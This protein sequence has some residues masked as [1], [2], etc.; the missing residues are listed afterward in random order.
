M[1]IPVDF[2][3]AMTAWAQRTPAVKALV[4]IGSRERKATDEIWR[5]DP[6]SDWD[7]QII[8][9]AAGRFSNSDWTREIG[10]NF[11]IRAYAS[12][13]A[14]IGGVPKVNAIFTGVETDF[15]ILSAGMMR[16]LKWLVLLGRHRMEGKVRRGLQDLAIVIRPGWRFLHGSEAWDPFYRKV[17]AEV[18]DLRLSDEAARGL[19][20]AFA[21]EQ[22]WT[23]RKIARGELSAAQRMLHRELAETNFRL[24]HELKLRRSE[25]SF[26]E[27][28]RIERVAS[29][30]ELEAVCVRATLD[31]GQLRAAVDHS[32]T[33]CERLMR[34]LV[35]ETWRR[36]V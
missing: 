31:A 12:R 17:V 28:R 7:F 10:K 16:L 21:C 14:R 8:T 19:A 29:A 30:R 33:T 25:R 35:G 27:G 4:L 34:D 26:P 2:G 11:E 23:L 1:S 15:V 18:P 32:A 13:V 20:H 24:L 22:L 36:L 6:E 5:A 9:S 3:E